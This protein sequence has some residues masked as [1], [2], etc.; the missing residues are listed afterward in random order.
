MKIK[1]KIKS[2]VKICDSLW[3]DLVK[4]NANYKCEKCGVTYYLASHHIIPRTCY[5]LRHD[6]E[7]GVCL[8]RRDHLYWAHKDALAFHGWIKGIRDLEYLESRR[9]S[10]SKNDYKLIEIYLKQQLDGK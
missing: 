10:Q 7:N 1:A 3:S 4:K 2:K 9:H 5:S 6:P 8:C